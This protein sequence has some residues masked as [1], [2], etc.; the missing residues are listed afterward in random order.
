MKSLKLTK[1]CI[2]LTRN[3]VKRVT[4]LNI[5][6]ILLYFKMKCIPLVAKLIFQQP[7]LQCSVSHNPLEIILMLIRY[8]R[9]F[10]II[11]YF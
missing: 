1:H 6:V 8:L 7:L 10:I 9:F 11:S 3:T 4:F 5:N 2:Y